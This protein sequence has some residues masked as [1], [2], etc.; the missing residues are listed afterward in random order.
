MDNEVYSKNPQKDKSMMVCGARNFEWK[1]NFV[2][3]DGKM[4]THYYEDALRSSL[5][6]STFKFRS[7]EW[8]F[9]QD[10]TAVN[11]FHL[12]KKFLEEND[13][14]IV[15]WQAKSSDLTIIENVGEELVR[16]VQTNEITCKSDLYLQ[17]SIMDAWNC[18]YLH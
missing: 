13:V 6:S 1:Q 9:P 5:F 16:R 15:D 11:R 2:D 18:S 7:D 8:V 17:D 10:N 3:I 14:E 12:S 4:E